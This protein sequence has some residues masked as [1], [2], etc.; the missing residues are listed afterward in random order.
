MSGISD[1]YEGFVRALSVSQEN[2]MPR[3]DF[4]AQMKVP[5]F[6]ST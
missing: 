3:M 4:K 2:Q 6:N 1:P 5:A